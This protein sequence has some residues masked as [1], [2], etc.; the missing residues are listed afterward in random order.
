ME[1]KLNDYQHKAMTTCKDSSNN[2]QYMLLNLVSEVGEV[3]GLIAKGIRKRDIDAQVLQLDAIDKGRIM[4]ELGDVLWQ[5]AGVCTV[6]DIDFNEVALQNLK[7]LAKRN[8]SNTI[9][10]HG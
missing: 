9:I 7:K 4:L 8:E 3:C 6:L 1:L 10:D 5:L 2:I